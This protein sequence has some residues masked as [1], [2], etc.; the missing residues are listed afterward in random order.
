MFEEDKYKEGRIILGITVKSMASIKECEK[1]KGVALAKLQAE[2]RQ[3]RKACEVGA[4]N[5]RLVANM[6]AS[7][8]KALDSLFNSHGAYVVKMY[9]QQYITR[10]IRAAYDVRAAAKKV[11]LSEEVHR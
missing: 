1:S 10:L 7:L 8:Y 11:K 6:V 2:I 9:G 4:P 3:L 5:K